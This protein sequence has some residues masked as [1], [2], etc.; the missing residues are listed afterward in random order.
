MYLLLVNL[1]LL[2]SL[3]E[4]FIHGELDCF[5]GAGN[6]DDL[7]KNVLVDEAAKDEFALFWE[8][9]AELEVEVF[10]CF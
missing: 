9:I 5:L 3:E 4:R 1:S 7:E 10:S 2:A 8:A 6:R